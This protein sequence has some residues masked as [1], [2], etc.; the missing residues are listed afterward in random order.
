M[1]P[2]VVTH[3][4]T[5]AHC[6]AMPTAPYYLGRLLR[7]LWLCA[8]HAAATAQYTEVVPADME[9]TFRQ[10]TVEHLGDNATEHDLADFRAACEAIMADGYS[11]TEATD[12]V[13]NDG[14]W[15]P[16]VY[17]VLE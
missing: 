16:I 9:I 14:D 12:I 3:T 4:Q 2:C 6:P 11:E 15:A 7:P 5:G 17:G 13:W 10:M 1:Q 8:P